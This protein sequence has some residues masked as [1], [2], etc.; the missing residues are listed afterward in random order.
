MN[1]YLEAF[2]VGTLPAELCNKTVRDLR[3]R[4]EEL[5]VEKRNLEARRERL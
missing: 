3:A 4:L 2:E 5:E 1:R